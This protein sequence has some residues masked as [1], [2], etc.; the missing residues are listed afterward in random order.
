MATFFS[1]KALVSQRASGYKSTAYALAELIDNS[2]DADAK[3]VH[4]TLV[5]RKVNGRRQV[6]EIVIYDDGTGMSPNLL[7]SALQFGHTTNDNIEEVVTSKKKGKFGYG[8]PNA[9]LS[10]CKNIHVYSWTKPQDFHHVYLDLEELEANNS[11][12]WTV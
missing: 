9:S 6:E 2:F 10:Q 11:I 8:L 4:I 7:Q 5:E 3:E 12:E 1:Y